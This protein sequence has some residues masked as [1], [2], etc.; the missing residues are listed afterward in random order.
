[1]TV[2][3][4]SAAR[5]C[6]QRGI[7]LAFLIL[8]AGAGLLHADERFQWRSWGV[9]DGLTETYSYAVSMTPEASAY[10][11]HGSVLS[12]SLFDGYHV[13]RIP[14]PRGNAQPDWQ[15][16]KRVYGGPRG[17]CG[18]IPQTCSKSTAMENGRFGIRRQQVTGC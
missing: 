13:T 1:M 18:P 16:T 15:S 7:I 12:M 3:R 2:Q 4:I 10:I 11:R 14:E 5:K 8:W 17:T 6:A 9:R